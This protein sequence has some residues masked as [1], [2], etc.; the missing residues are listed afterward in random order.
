MTPGHEHARQQAGRG[1]VVVL[2]GDLTGM[3][4]DVAVNAANETLAHGGGI[5]AA[6][7]RAGGPDVQRESD[8]WV[9]EHGQVGPGMA[10]VTT[11]GDMPAR[12][13]V[14]VVGPRYRDGQENE[15]LL[16]QAVEAALDASAGL[17][18]TSVALPAISAGVFGYPRAD[19]TRVIAATCRDW[20]QRHPDASVTDIRLVGFD[21]AAAADFATAVDS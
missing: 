7:S 4:V 16:R 5:A 12:W 20:L 11:A 10:A 15:A 17:S 18:A 6:L 9:A 19:A 1:T 3:E 21:E 13:L 8:A 14:H 2:Q